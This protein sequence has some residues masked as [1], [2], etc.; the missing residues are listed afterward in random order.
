MTGSTDANAP[1]EHQDALSEVLADKWW[2]VGLRGLIGIIFGLICIFVPAAAI[3][4]LIIFFSAYMLVDGAL[5]IASGIKAARN[6][7][8]WGL[9]IL[10]GIVDLAAGA[11]AFVWPGI[12]AVAFV[13]L[14]GVWAFISGG[15]LVAAAFSLKLDHGRWWLV[16]AGIASVI[17]GI[18]LLVSPVVGAVVLTWWVGAYAIAF[19]IMLIILAFKLRGK[20]E[21]HAAKA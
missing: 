11:I 18:L 3:L 10:E 21:E 4:T 1:A 20:K 13:L 9:L 19:G 16:L 8:R 7:K 5:A 14:V 2:T 17:F 15:L 6:G 12:T